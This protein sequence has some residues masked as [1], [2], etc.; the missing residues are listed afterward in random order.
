MLESQGVS[1]LLRISVEEQKPIW[2]AAHKVPEYYQKKVFGCLSFVANPTRT[3][4]KFQLRG[5][6]CVILKFPQTQKGCKLLNLLAK[7]TFVSNDVTFSKQV[8]PY[9]GDSNKQYLQPLYTCL[10]RASTWSD[11]CLNL[12][13]E[14]ITI[15]VEQN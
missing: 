4:D 2:S 9:K 15:L 11:D 12:S 10:P 14:N 13:L 7:A 8:L 3:K 6:P 1:G 5:A